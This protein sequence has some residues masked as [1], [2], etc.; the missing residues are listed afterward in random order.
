MI[1]WIQL[2]RGKP[3]GLIDGQ[4]IAKLGSRNKYV[5][6]KSD[7]SV[8]KARANECCYDDLNAIGC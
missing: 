6:E 1:A 7:G 3:S 5:G 8:P 4:D 2:T